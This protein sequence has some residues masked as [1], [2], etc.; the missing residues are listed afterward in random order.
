MRVRIKIYD[1][2]LKDEVSATRQKVKLSFLEISVIDDAILEAFKEQN[3]DF[4][5]MVSKGKSSQNS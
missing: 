5:Q 3:E 2:I 1:D 4:E